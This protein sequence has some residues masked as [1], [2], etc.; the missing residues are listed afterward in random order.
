MT[1][2]S[3]ALSLWISALIAVCVGTVVFI[4]FS[5]ITD[6]MASSSNTQADHPALV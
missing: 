3:S 5:V 6:F 1:Q 4:E 2:A